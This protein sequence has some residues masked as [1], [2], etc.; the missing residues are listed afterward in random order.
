MVSSEVLRR[1]ATVFLSYRRENVDE[2]KYLQQQLHLRGV[3]AWRDVT[4][5]DLGTK[6]KDEITRAIGQE[7]DAF[8]LYL[9]QECLNS[10]FVWN[11]EVPAA[12]SRREKDSAFGIVPVLRG[13]SIDQLHNFCTDRRYP[14][15][16]DFNCAVLPDI[17]TSGADTIFSEAI[18]YATKLILRAALNLRLRRVEADPASYE[19]HL[20]LHTYPYEISDS[21]DLDLNWIEGFPTREKPEQW[22]PERGWQKIFLPALYDVKDAVSTVAHSRRLHITVQTQLAVAFA[23]GFIFP[24]AADFR[25]ILKSRDGFW[26]SDEVITE[27]EP[28][29][30]QSTDHPGDKRVAIVEISVSWPVTPSVSEALPSF[31][32]SFGHRVH[33]EVK[34]GA[35]TDAVQS[36]AH[37]LAL[38]RQVGRELRQLRAY[39]RITHMHVFLSCPAPLAVLLGH[40]C[41]ALGTITLYHHVKEADKYIPGYTLNLPGM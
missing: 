7:C 31:G 10:E 15:L 25:L 20:C 34:G 41:N 37:A 11:V 18:G 27:R 6:N 21:L 32:I 39:K 4:H 33:F 30:V 1:P 36:A 3:R 29:I 40:Y 24:E 2:A 23:L 26:T 35:S 16:T 8:L 14:D 28:L 12:F 9:T 5:L 19:P 22:P 17:G 13:V 38:A